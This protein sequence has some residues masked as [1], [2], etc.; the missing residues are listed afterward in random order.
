M[1]WLVG[2]LVR[3]ARL[4]RPHWEDENISS[5]KSDWLVNNVINWIMP[6]DWSIW[7]WIGQSIITEL[8]YE[9]IFFTMEAFLRF[10]L[11]A[12]GLSCGCAPGTILD[13][14]WTIVCT[15]HVLGGVFFYST[16][17]RGPRNQ[18]SAARNQICCICQHRNQSGM[19]HLY[20]PG[21]APALQPCS[22]YGGLPCLPP[23]FF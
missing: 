11:Y 18:F 4:V 10:L 13:H 5:C 17:D 6:S 1:G 22:G 23:S 8:G 14:S 9:R 21:K 20:G 7:H 19:L 15:M 2:L 16:T 12:S 3:Q